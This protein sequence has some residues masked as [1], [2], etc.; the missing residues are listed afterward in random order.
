M[1]FRTHLLRRN[2]LRHVGAAACALALGSLPAAAQNATDGKVVIGAIVDMTGVYSRHGG[3]GMVSAVQMA[4]EDFGGKVN[5]KPIE[6]LSADYQNKV[7]VTSGVA[8][9]WFDNDGVDMVIES[10]DSASAL[11]LFRLGDEKKRVIIGAGSATTALTNAGCMPYG[12][13]YV[14]DTYALATGT[15]SAIVKEGGKTWFF[16]TADYAFGHALEADTSRVVLAGGGKVLGN[17]R[18]PLSTT[19]FSSF[20]LQAQSSKAQVIGLAN[21]GGD[22]VN[23]VKQASEFGITQAGQNL[24]A[25]L[26]FITDVKALG[27]KVAQGLKFTTGFYW[28]RDAESRAFSKTYY[29]RNNAQP[30]MVQAG[31][32]SATMHYLNAVKAVGSEDAAKVSE[33][34]KANPVNDFFAKNGVIRADG[35]MVHDMYLAE[36]KA[37]ADSKNEWDLMKILRTIPGDEAFKPLAESTC[38][39][40]KKS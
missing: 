33:W 22:F 27:L 36:A 18:A 20:L 40:V 34:M 17:A 10:T 8:R 38:T 14:Y 1:T 19:D 11:A 23:S 21:A 12:I 31:A 32:Y 29:A 5:G 7:D 9:R 3:P 24:A 13:H 30:S 25:M 4:V 2:L 26:V 35:R 15:G 28:D 39:L 6:V 37:P 16:I